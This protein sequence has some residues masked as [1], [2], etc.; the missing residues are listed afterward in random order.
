MRRESVEL[1]PAHTPRF[2]ASPSKTAQPYSVYFPVE[3]VERAITVRPAVIA[4]MASQHSCIP[5][6]LEYQWGVQ[7]PPSVAK[8]AEVGHTHIIAGENVGVFSRLRLSTRSIHNP[9][10]PASWITTKG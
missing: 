1:L 8:D 9:S 5:G 2:L 6:M 3:A 4:I 7:K 10:S